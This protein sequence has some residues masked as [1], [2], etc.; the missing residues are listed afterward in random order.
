MT[1]NVYVAGN[2]YMFSLNFRDFSGEVNVVNN[3][4]ITIVTVFYLFCLCLFV[5]NIYAFKTLFKA[6]HKRQSNQHFQSWLA[7]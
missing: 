1:S 5:F 2:S 4:K 7:I 3:C 6:L